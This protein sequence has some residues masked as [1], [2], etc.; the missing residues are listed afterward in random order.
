MTKNESKDDLET[1]EEENAGRGAPLP[2]FLR[3][4]VA[5]GLSSFFTTEEAIR[6][7]LGDT[8]P[9]D[10]VDFASQQSERTRSEMMDRLSAEFGRVLQEVDLVELAEHLLAGRT[11]E[12]RAEFRLGDREAD[13]EARTTVRLAGGKKERR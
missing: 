13:D 12:V 11:I 10:W 9:Q 4:A 5:L 2:D 3:R 1:G 8:V 6:K 7:A